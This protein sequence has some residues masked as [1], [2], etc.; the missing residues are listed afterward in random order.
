MK[1]I[2]IDDITLEYSTDSVNWTE[3]AEVYRLAPLGT[4]DPERLQHAYEAS[5]VC[6]FVYRGTQ[7]IGAGRGLS[8]GEY[9]RFH[10]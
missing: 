1:K 4:Y 5:Q 2:N 9:F 3:L 6:C 7:L 10:L 8:D